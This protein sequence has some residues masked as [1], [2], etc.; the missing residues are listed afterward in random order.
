MKKEWIPIMIETGKLK[1]KLM[2]LLTHY[3]IVIFLLIP[4]ILNMYSLIQKHLLD[5][6]TGVRSPEEM[7]VATSPFGIIAIFF[8]FIQRNRLKF[9]L[10]ETTISKEKIKEVIE[11]TSK[12]LDWNPVIIDS[13]LFVAKTHPHLLT[14]SWGEQITIIIE[15]NKILINSICDP[16]K[17]SSV[18]SFGRNRKNIRAFIENIRNASS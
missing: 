9:K 16:D 5:N 15:R 12:Q 6:Y 11:M 7:L 13:R 4:F 3:M 10:V 8:F 17:M 18:V 2:E 14:G 1:L